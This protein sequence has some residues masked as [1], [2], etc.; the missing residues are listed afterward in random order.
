VQVGNNLDNHNPR[1]LNVTR[2]AEC[3][4]ERKS[5]LLGYGG[6]LQTAVLV[7]LQEQVDGS[8]NVLFEKRAATLRRQPGEISFPGGHVEP[9]DAT[10]AATALRETAEELGVFPAAICL[11][12]PLDVLIASTGLIVHPFVGII[13]KDVPLYPNP[14]EV[15]KVLAISYDYL[16]TYTP[17]IHD[18]T[19]VPRPSVDF[20][21]HLLPGG[22]SYPLRESVQR[23]YFYRWQDH[24]IWGLTARV[25][26]H[27][28]NL[29]RPCVSTLGQSRLTDSDG[30]RN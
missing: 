18:V 7:A 11:L 2:L 19:L 4:T 3:L 17:A 26:Q 9:S 14:D 27:F 8:V 1:R 6:A 23:H 22:T 12:G 5:G 30:T 21:Y 16:A 13:D 15:E 20:P 10:M 24:V 25:L 28:L 29:A